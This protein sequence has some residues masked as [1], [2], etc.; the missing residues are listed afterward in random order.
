MTSILLRLKTCAYKMTTV[1]VKDTEQHC[2]YRAKLVD[3]KQD[4][5]LVQYEDSDAGP[6]RQAHSWVH[7]S[8]VRQE[9][10]K[11]SPVRIEPVRGVV[12]RPCAPK[13]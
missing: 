12:S 4:Q 8:L 6:Q 1:E 9:P 7:S 11:Q 13:G 10:P 3:I 2:Y 5:C